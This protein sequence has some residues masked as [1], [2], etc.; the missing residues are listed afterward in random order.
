LEKEKGH[1]RRETTANFDSPSVFTRRS[2]VRSNDTAG[3]ELRTIGLKSRTVLIVSQ[4]YGGT[5]RANCAASCAAELAASYS[6]LPKYEKPSYVNYIDPDVPKK[7][8]S[9]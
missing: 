3:S 9:T 4:H 5:T 7:R 6:I 2:A 1:T 8:Q